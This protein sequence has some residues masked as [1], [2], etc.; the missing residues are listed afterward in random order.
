MACAIVAP[1]ERDER[2]KMVERQAGP[3][4]QAW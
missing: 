2:L 4:S 1:A 3:F